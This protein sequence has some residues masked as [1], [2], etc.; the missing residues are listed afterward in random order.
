MAQ[1][2][3]RE[4]TVAEAGDELSDSHLCHLSVQEEVWKPGLNS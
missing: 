1:W 4:P 3:K 2:L